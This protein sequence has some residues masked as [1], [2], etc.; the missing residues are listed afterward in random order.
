[1]VDLLINFANKPKRGIKNLQKRGKIKLK[2][3]V[4]KIVI[5]IIYLILKSSFELNV[6]KT[7][8][9]GKIKME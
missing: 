6:I 5:N 7:K 8:L 9:I 4:R 3:D 1:M 2:K